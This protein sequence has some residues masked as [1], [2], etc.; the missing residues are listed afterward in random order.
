MLSPFRLLALAAL[1]LP[2][3]AQSP[4]YHVG[5]AATA[6]DIAERDIVALWPE[7]ETG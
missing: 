5:R 1:S 3:L 6:A 4:T 7:R 2:L